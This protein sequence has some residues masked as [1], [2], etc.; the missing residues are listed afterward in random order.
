M[1]KTIILLT[2]ITLASC[3]SKVEPEKTPII[4]IDSIPVKIDINAIKTNTVILDTLS[5]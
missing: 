1:K 4:T 3:G 2:L 5:N